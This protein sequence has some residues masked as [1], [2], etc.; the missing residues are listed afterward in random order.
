[1]IKSILF[2]ILIPFSLS[3]QPENTS[4]KLRRTIDVINYSFHL[5][6]NDQTND[7]SGEATITIRFL[8]NNAASFSLDLIDRPAETDSTGMQVTTMLQEGSPVEFRHENNQLQI[9]RFRPNLLPQH[10]IPHL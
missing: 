4:T 7:I 3:A 2:I 1:M 9:Q 10:R 6:L 8:E 5:N